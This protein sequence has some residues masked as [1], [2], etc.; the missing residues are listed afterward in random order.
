[1]LYMIYIQSRV[2][3]DLDLLLVELPLK[4]GKHNFALAGLE[5]IHDIGNGALKVS[6]RE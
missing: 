6:T 1:M 5:A 2:S 4:T 3:P